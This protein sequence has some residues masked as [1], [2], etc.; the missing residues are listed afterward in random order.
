[1]HYKNIR[2]RAATVAL[3]A[4]VILAI[5]G[6]HYTYRSFLPINILSVAEARA[7]RDS[8]DRHGAFSA[9]VLTHFWDDFLFRVRVVDA[10]PVIGGGSWMMEHPLPPIDLSESPETYLIRNAARIKVGLELL[11]R[12]E[13]DPDTLHRALESDLKAGRCWPIASYFFA[14]RDCWDRLSN[15]RTNALQR[16]GSWTEPIV[17]AYSNYL[18]RRGSTDTDSPVLVLRRTPIEGTNVTG[19]WH[20]RPLA[21]ARMVTPDFNETIYAY[22]QTLNRKSGD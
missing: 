17:S 14:A 3:L 20:Y 7:Y 11:A 10:A 13:F 19:L 16:V 5:A 2:L 21:E 4:F 1:M 18:Q 9:V 22:V 12:R 6:H 15:Y 8:I